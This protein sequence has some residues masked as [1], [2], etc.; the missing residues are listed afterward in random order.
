MGN[1]HSKNGRV[2][3]SMS[4]E[5]GRISVGQCIIQGLNES[6]GVASGPL[7]MGGREVGREMGKQVECLPAGGMSLGV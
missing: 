7:R 6:G 3:S 1:E 2:K 5:V 4:S